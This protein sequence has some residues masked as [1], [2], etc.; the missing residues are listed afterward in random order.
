[1]L[2]LKLNKQFIKADEDYVFGVLYVPPSQE[3]LKDGEILALEIEILSIC[4]THKYVFLTGDIHARTEKLQDFITVDKFLADFSEF[5]NE[6]LNFYNQAELL[7]NFDTSVNRT[8]CDNVVNT[9]GYK[10]IEI[11]RGN[12]LFI[13]NGRL[14]T[15]REALIGTPP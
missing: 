6:T 13:V 1:M 14:G 10:L 15:G 2:W 3:F 11:C 12:N 7:K 8:S 5:D 9:N 4:S